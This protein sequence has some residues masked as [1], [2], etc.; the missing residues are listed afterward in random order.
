MYPIPVSACAKALGQ[1]VYLRLDVNGVTL[2]RDRL[3]PAS[4]TCE[5]MSFIVIHSSRKIALNCCEAKPLEG[6]QSVRGGRQRPSRHPGPRQ[7]E[8]CYSV[9]DRHRIMPNDQT[10]QELA[11]R[12]VFNLDRLPPLPEL[13]LHLKDLPFLVG[14][15]FH[16]QESVVPVIC[17]DE[18]CIQ[19]KQ[20]SHRRLECLG[21]WVLG[22]FISNWIQR[23][24][25]I[26]VHLIRVG[27]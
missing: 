10:A 13:P 22:L 2:F 4:F 3:I 24:P 15:H 26:G 11:C 6:D 9:T 20:H 1:G 23:D 17:R 12:L 16:A 14:T 8:I 27:I 19:A 7:P 5:A 18:P 21:G 25:E